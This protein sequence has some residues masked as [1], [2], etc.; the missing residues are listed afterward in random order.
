VVVDFS[1]SSYRLLWD[2]GGFEPLGAYGG[3]EGGSGA[4][5][6]GFSQVEVCVA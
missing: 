2:S 5:F 1:S 3:G 6:E 4:L